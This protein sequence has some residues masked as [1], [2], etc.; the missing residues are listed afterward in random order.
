MK[1]KLFSI[2]LIFLLSSPSWSETLTIDDLVKRDNL[3]HKKFINVPFTGEI[4]GVESGSLKH[5]KKDGEW[6]IYY[7]SG[8]VYS[9][10]KKIRL[11]DEKYS[12]APKIE[13][14]DVH[15]KTKR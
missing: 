9:I 13:V 11:R 6:T 2:I 3:Y 12:Q 14:R 10:L 15:I 1:R 7:E 4:S 8:H 5:G